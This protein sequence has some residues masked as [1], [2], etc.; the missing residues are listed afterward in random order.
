MHRISHNCQERP[1]EPDLNLPVLRVSLP[2]FPASYQ[3]ARGTVRHP[4]EKKGLASAI[5]PLLIFGVV[6]RFIVRSLVNHM[7]FLEG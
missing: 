4:I 2:Q 5:A 3:Q 1:V 6:I 7:L